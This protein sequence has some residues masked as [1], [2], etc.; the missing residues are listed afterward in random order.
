[1][2]KLQMLIVLHVIELVIMLIGIFSIV[3]SMISGN[4]NIHHSNGRPY[5]KIFV[6]FGWSLWTYSIMYADYNYFFILNQRPESA[7]INYLILLEIWN[8]I[9]TS[10]TCLLLMG[11][12][13]RWI[14]NDDK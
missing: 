11:N 8:I 1:M 4:K 5:V 7:T 3:H 6:A 12:E 14:K 13:F 10:F 2:F 9:V